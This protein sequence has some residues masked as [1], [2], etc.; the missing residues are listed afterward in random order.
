[1]N[2]WYLTNI[3]DYSYL[4]YARYIDMIK[5]LCQFSIFNF[6][7]LQYFGFFNPQI[8]EFSNINIRILDISKYLN[9]QIFEVLLFL[10]ISIWY[11]I[12]P[13]HFRVKLGLKNT[14]NIDDMVSISSLSS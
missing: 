9:P 2:L 7:K 1:M 8:S 5:N 12:I 3:E 14:Q 6:L 4:R 13:S 11:A 10:K